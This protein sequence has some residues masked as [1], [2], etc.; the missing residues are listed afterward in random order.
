MSKKN[1][2]CVALDPERFLTAW[3]KAQ[4]M[5]DAPNVTPLITRMPIDMDDRT[6]S[7]LANSEILRWLAGV[8]DEFPDQTEG[9]SC[10]MRFFAITGLIEKGLLGPFY[11][12]KYGV[13]TDA[14]RVLAVAR[15]HV[16]NGFN[17]PDVKERLA[18]LEPPP[19]PV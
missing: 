18:K 2:M 14:L 3:N 12:P 4:E 13:W 6:T 15:C 7:H 11:N 19:S 5:A 9:L 16:T 17:E 1:Q 10:S 8:R